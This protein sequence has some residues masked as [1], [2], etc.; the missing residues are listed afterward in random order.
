PEALAALTSL[1]R[2]AQAGWA[3]L[4]GEQARLPAHPHRQGR[5]SCAPPISPGPCPRIDW[6]QTRLVRR[7]GPRGYAAGQEGRVGARGHGFPAP[8]IPASDDGPRPPSPGPAEIGVL[9]VLGRV[10]P[11]VL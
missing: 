5:A 9:H 6:A 11:A 1:A 7:A 10:A 4:A 8:G 3:R 2:T